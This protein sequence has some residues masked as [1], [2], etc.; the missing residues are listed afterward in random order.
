MLYIAILGHVLYRDV[1]TKQATTVG[2]MQSPTLP[3]K[4]PPVPS[5][6]HVYGV[7]VLAVAWLVCR[8]FALDIGSC[9]LLRRSPAPYLISNAIAL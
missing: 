1:M 8:L 6:S 3:F 4:S 9:L 2:D 5:H 7:S